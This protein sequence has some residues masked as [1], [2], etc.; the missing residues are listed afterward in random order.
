MSEPILSYDELR[1]LES[2]MRD[3]TKS[4][5]ERE[6]AKSRFYAQLALRMD[7]DIGAL[8]GAFARLS[9]VTEE[10]NASAKEL[11]LVLNQIVEQ[12]LAALTPEQRQQ[13]DHLIAH[14]GECVLDAV[15]LVTG[16]LSDRDGE[17]PGKPVER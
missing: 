14:E 8:A 9:R 11:G 2:I 5:E 7:M 16:D 4:A 3:M 13:V 1:I 17:A 12:E 15:W 10:A 6:E